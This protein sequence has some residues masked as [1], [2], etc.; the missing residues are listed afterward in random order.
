MRILTDLLDCVVD[1]VKQINNDVSFY[2]YSFFF[3]CQFAYVPNTT[4]TEYGKFTLYFCNNNF[5]FKDN[6]FQSNYW[7]RL[8]HWLG[9]SFDFCPLCN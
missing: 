6:T 1:S 5:K 2:V 4:E 9:P 7:Q 8:G 3:I